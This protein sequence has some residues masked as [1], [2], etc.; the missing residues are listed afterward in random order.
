MLC[1]PV[2]L[3]A[4]RAV[5]GELFL[6]TK[7]A[8]ILLTVH[9]VGGSRGVAPPRM[10]SK[11]TAK[12]AACKAAMHACAPFSFI[13]AGCRKSYARDDRGGSSSNPKGRASNRRSS[14]S[15]TGMNKEK[16]TAY[17]PVSCAFTLLLQKTRRFGLSK[18]KSY[19][20]L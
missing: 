6:R 1:V 4:S 14:P 18:H 3:E 10:F 9:K 11:V 15:L 7:N 19:F 16:R 8:Y 13:T 17:T 2:G 5:Y 12:N 20:C